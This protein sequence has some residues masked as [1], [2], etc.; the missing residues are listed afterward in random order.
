MQS[1]STSSA[2]ATPVSSPSLS[3]T[4]TSVSPVRTMRSIAAFTLSVSRRNAF[5]RSMMS[6]AQT[7]SGSSAP[8]RRKKEQTSAG[9]VRATISSRNAGSWRRRATPAATRR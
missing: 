4:G 1:F 9:D 8:P 2:E 3:T 5:G 7:N 6:A